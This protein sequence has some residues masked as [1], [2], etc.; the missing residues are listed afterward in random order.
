MFDTFPATP[1]NSPAYSVVYSVE[2]RGVQVGPEIELAPWSSAATHQ[3]FTYRSQ[4]THFP[5]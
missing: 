5:N 4:N 2:G 3:P 1:A